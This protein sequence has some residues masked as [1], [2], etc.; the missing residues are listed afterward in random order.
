MSKITE[1]A[2]KHEN[3]KDNWIV[4][5]GLH[6]FFNDIV[7]NGMDGLKESSQSSARKF[8]LYGTRNGHL[9]FFPDEFTIPALNLESLITS[10]YCGNY[11]K[12]IP[13]YNMLRAHNFP[14]DVKKKLNV[15]CPKWRKWWK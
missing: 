14:E 6:D 9:Q 5:G 3:L 11:S 13:P 2:F 4:N 1:V 10:W 7:E 12:G 15:S 8:V